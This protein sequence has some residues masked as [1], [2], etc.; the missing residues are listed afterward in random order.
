M[1]VGHNM[2]LDLIFFVSCFLGPLPDDIQEFLIMV[3]KLFPVLIDTKDLAHA[4][5]EDSPSYR[6]SSLE[7]LDDELSHL[8]MPIIGRKPLSVRH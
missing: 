6:K 4:F 8:D 1:L 7:E 5:H 3:R 2:L